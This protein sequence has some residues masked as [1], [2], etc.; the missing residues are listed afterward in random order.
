[1]VTYYQAKSYNRLC[2]AHNVQTT[3]IL[4]AQ[5]SNDVKLKIS[6]VDIPTKRASCD[7]ASA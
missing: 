7:R 6:F 1:M 5:S 4:L 2:S 3:S